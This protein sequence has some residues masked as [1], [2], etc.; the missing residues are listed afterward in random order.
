MLSSSTYRRVQ[1]FYMIV[2]FTILLKVS[3]PNDAR[4]VSSANDMSATRLNDLYVYLL[5]FPAR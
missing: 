3:G 2:M 4:A 1:V 5:G